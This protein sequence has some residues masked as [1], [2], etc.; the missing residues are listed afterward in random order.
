M[1]MTAILNFYH[2]HGSLLNLCAFGGLLF[3]G[4]VYI[5][6]KFTK[7]ALTHFLHVAIVS[8][9]LIFFLLLTLTPMK[10]E[11]VPGFKSLQIST[12]VTHLLRPQLA[13]SAWP[14]WHDPVGNIMLT[15]PLAFG[16]GL[17]W[18]YWRVIAATAT[19]STSIEITQHFFV[20]GRTAQVSDVILNTTGAVV[21]VAIVSLSYAVARKISVR[22]TSESS[23]QR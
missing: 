11:P 23:K 12:V 7:P 22:S 18:S 8:S 21:G 17:T 9:G 3:F 1:S 10:Y 13:T 14:D 16:L 2:A 5:V 19:L 20:H 6:M 4:T 15:V